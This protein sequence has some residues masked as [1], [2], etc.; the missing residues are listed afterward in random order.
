MR[1]IEITTVIGCPV[2]C[3]FCP[4]KKLQASYKGER[5]FTIDTFDYIIN[6][7]P[8]DVRID[9]SGFAEPFLNGYCKQFIKTCIEQQRKIAIYSTLMYCFESDLKVI[10]QAK[11]AGL[12]QAF[13]VHLPDK[14]GNTRAVYRDV[15]EY[16]MLLLE[17]SELGAGFVAHGTP[18]DVGV[19]A[20]IEKI[21]SRGGNLNNVESVCKLGMI[22][23]TFT[24]LDHNVLLP[25]G[26]VI[27]CCMDYSLEWVL[28]N[29]FRQTYEQIQRSPIKDELRGRNLGQVD[30]LCR[31]CINSQEIS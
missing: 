29:L 15:E 30:T 24:D 7:V 27:L 9:F 10:R 5:S 6:K 2:A 21:H 18:Q 19:S 25:N 11:E 22:D 1:T 3:R 17:A 26:D 23:C 4:Q 13:V 8:D 28:G 16:K 31:R 14:Q 12:L 20:F